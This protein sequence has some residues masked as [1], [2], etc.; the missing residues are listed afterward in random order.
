MSV[1]SKLIYAYSRAAT[2]NF[3]YLSPER[4]GA[5]NTLIR[6]VLRNLGG[7]TYVEV[8]DWV[9]RFKNVSLKPIF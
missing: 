8:E 4:H 7:E 5:T 6:L 3:Q 9:A 2:R 1:D